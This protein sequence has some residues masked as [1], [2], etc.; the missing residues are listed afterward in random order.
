MKR[1]LETSLDEPRLIVC[2]ADASPDDEPRL[3]QHQLETN[4][5]VNGLPNAGIPSTTGRIGSPSTGHVLARKTIKRAGAR[6]SA[7]FGII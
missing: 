6:R 4:R 2:R 7:I 5:P 3:F 1:Q